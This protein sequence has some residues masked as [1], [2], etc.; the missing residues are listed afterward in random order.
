MKKTIKLYVAMMLI[1]MISGC[2]SI[3]TEEITA[4]VSEAES[5]LQVKQL[6]SQHKEGFKTLKGN[7]QSTKLMDIWD[8]KYQL[9]G[10]NCQIWR[11][12]NGK[13][14]YMCSLTVPNKEVANEKIDKAINFTQQCLGKEWSTKNIERKKSGAFRT[15]FSKQGMNTVASMHGVNTGGLFESEWTV[16][17]FIGDADRTL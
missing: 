4:T 7:Y 17:Y 10:K 15:I 11:W 12:S 5:C 8:A 13:Q 2:N 14:A 6:V 3:K 1:L 9:V 16:Y